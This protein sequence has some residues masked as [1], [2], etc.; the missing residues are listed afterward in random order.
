MSILL[1]LEKFS[2]TVTRNFSTRVGPAE[3]LKANN[4]A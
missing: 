1:A 2:A 3:D 4:F